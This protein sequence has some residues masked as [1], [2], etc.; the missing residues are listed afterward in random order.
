MNEL[1]L[2]MRDLI[3]RSGLTFEDIFRMALG[4]QDVTKEITDYV[5][6]GYAPEKV[7]EFIL[8]GDV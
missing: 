1:D 7:W 3:R 4:T 6:S 2:K 8:Q 5:I